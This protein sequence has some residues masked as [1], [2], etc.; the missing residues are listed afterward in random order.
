[1]LVGPLLD[2]VEDRRT[3]I[4]SPTVQMAKDVA[5]FIN[6]RSRAVCT[7]GKTKWYPTLLIG[8]GAAC[9]CGRLAEAFDI[10]RNNQAREL[11][12][13]TVDRDP[14]YAGHQSGEFQFLSI[15]GLCLARNSR[16]LTDHGEVPIQNV[17]PVMRLWDGIEFVSHGGVISKGEKPVITYAGL[18]ATEDHN[19][20]TD[21]G[22]Q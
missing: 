13:M 8:D 11:D 14:I 4:F 5:S 20:W 7:C 17:T 12:G 22:W 19:I 10:D 6:A 2:M 21:N 18:T 16:I 1:T 15:C 3:L 9:E